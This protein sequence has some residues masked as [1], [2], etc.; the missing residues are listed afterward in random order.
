MKH[1]LYCRK[2]T[3]SEDRQVL[4]LD[5]QEKEM[6][7]I[8]LKQGI[9]VI[10]VFRESQSAKTAGRPIF[11]E[12]IQMIQ[13]GKADSIICWKLDRLARNF[14][15]G[16]LIMDMLQRGVIKEIRTS[17]AIHLPNE[18]AFIMAM[19]FGMANQ[20]SRDLS[21]NVKRGNRACL[22]KG[23]W[24]NMA[25]F[26]YLNDKGNKAI[27]IDEE[28]AKY[29]VKAFELYAT[30]K[31]F[32]EISDILYSEGLR[33]RSGTKVYRSH[34]HR[35]IDNP[36]YCGLMKRD[37][38]LYPG[39]FQPIISKELF[40]RVQQ[41]LHNKNRPR[42]KTI[43]FP[44]RGFLK[45]ANCGCA[46]TASLKKG[47]QYYYCTNG[48][49][50][51]EEHKSYMRSEYLHET[52]ANLLESL[53]IREEKIEIMYEAA[54]EKAGAD[55]AYLDSALSS[56]QTRLESLTPKENKLLDTFLDNQIS[57]E[58]YDA[59]VLELRND[60]VSTQKQ[61]NDLKAKQPV[62]TLE[63]TK[64]VFLRGS[65]AKSEF[66]DADD[67]KKQDIISKLLWNLSIKNKTV[68]EVSYK[69][70]YDILAK[71]PKNADIL[72]LRREWD[73]NPRF[74]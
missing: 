70:P 11:N 43:F 40:E 26:G 6:L 22:E 17:E 63:P 57:K 50:G 37:G 25:P 20:Y 54:K 8:A 35:F 13:S 66:M 60:R 23:G 7:E 32:K 27:V 31:S 15:D 18:T 29:V 47:H 4:S 55:S 69:S 39:N 67:V 1:I 33:T 48:K 19:Q 45:C 28:R 14:L 41:V 53:H 38:K 56:L 64:E 74:P 61:I 51:C 2:S 12:V 24:P 21:T 36:F 49:G 46:L 73:L 71:I 9:K 5:S 65:R 34:I 72:Q 16:G 10:K 52:V 30:G 3:E 68:A 59:K 44:L 58:I 62:F 42:T